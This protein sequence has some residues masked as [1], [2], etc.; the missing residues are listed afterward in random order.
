MDI[1]A[2]DAAVGDFDVDVGGGEGL[3]GE[4]LV[5]Q[6]SLGRGRGMAEKHDGGES[7][8]C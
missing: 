3:W 8:E 2:A 6:I 4:G 7:G 1:G 5:S